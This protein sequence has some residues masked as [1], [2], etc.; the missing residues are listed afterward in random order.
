MAETKRKSESAKPAIDS[1]MQAR[2]DRLTLA[3]YLEGALGIIA[4]MIVISQ[5][6]SEGKADP[7]VLWIA[8]SLLG[9]LVLGLLV[10]ILIR[11][12]TKQ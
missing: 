8:G 10:T 1:E 7:T 2:R 6:L 5:F 3:L 11:R 9:I 12:K 4:G